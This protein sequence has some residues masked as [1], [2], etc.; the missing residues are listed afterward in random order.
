MPRSQFAPEP[1]LCRFRLERVRA[2][3]VETL[4]GAHAVAAGRQRQIHLPSALGAK[5]RLHS[6]PRHYLL[7]WRDDG[8][9]AV[10]A[11]VDGEGWPVLGLG[12]GCIV[13]HSTSA[14]VAD[15][16]GFPVFFLRHGAVRS[17]SFILPLFP[18]I[19][20][21]KWQF[22]RLRQIRMASEGA[23]HEREG[24]RLTGRKPYSRGGIAMTSWQEAHL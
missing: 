24:P 10:I 20:G 16:R 18:N 5:I 4:P 21:K 3:A 1:G 12:Q 6:R 11:P 14:F 15:R 13:R 23:M 9:A 19:S 22:L 8:R 2:I 7:L 17:S